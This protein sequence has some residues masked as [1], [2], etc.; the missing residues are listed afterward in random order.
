[1]KKLISLLLIITIVF[2]SFFTVAYT[3]PAFKMNE[4][5]NIRTIEIVNNKINYRSVFNKVTNGLKITLNGQTFSYDLTKD[6]AYEVLKKIRVKQKTFSNFEYFWYTNNEWK[7][8]RPDPD[9]PFKTHYFKTMQN[10]KNYDA[11]REYRDVVNI[12]NSQEGLCITLA[13]LDTFLA[14][15]I[16]VLTGQIWAVGVTSGAIA[17]LLTANNYTV[18]IAESCTGGMLSSILTDIPGSSDYFQ[19]GFVALIC[20]FCT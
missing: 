20:V 11:L 5:N 19:V 14:V 12:I 9:N 2:S 4:D 13:G 1:M 16:G 10:S 8:K 17:K 6:D 3:Q 7:L 18:A 15:C